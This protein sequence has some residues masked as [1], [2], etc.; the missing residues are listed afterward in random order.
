M[1]NAKSRLDMEGALDE[2]GQQN[3]TAGLMVR[4]PTFNY[5]HPTA[6]VLV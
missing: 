5:A 6:N 2:A 1:D 4:K 3:L